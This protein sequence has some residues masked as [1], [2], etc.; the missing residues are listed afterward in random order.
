MLRLAIETVDGFVAV[1][2]GRVIAALMPAP[3]PGVTVVRPAYM[4]NAVVVEK[5]AVTLA[6]AWAL[7]VPVEVRT[8][9]GF[10]LIFIPLILANKIPLALCCKICVV[11]VVLTD[12]LLTC[13]LKLKPSPPPEP[14][15]TEQPS[16]TGFTLQLIKNEICAPIYAQQLL[17]VIPEFAVSE[18][19]TIGEATAAL[20]VGL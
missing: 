4:L 5:A 6:W 13:K 17:H 9:L 19:K 3:E 14:K 18:P 11:I 1:A 8:A 15:Y 12:G 20:L 10:A 7:M 16:A 2:C